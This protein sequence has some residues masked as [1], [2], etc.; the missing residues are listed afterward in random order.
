MIE[1]VKIGPWWY[2]IERR[3]I[4]PREI[5][6]DD[7]DTDLE[8]LRPA[9]AAFVSIKKIALD[10]SDNELAVLSHEL[11]HAIAKEYA[12]REVARDEEALA[13]VLGNALI[14]FIIDNP[15]VVGAVAG[16]LAEQGQIKDTL[17]WI[18]LE[19]LQLRDQAENLAEEINKI[20]KDLGGEGNE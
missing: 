12:V 15:E 19:L 10:A 17:D 11:G 1:R 5:Y 20:L 4:D 9:G 13:D 2:K 18:R 16:Y 8:Q 14:S 6:L 7:D 3:K